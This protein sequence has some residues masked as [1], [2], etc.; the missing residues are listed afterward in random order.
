MTR[1]SE[2]RD[3]MA[4]SLRRAAA[5]KSTRDPEQEEVSAVESDVPRRPIPPRSKPVRITV[6][7]APDLHRRLKLWSAEESVTTADVLRTLA[8]RM[9]SDPTLADDVRRALAD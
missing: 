1:K 7:L 5:E 3:R 4:A 9:L 6:D 2:Q 8:G